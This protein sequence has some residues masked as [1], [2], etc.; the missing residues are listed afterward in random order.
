MEPCK[1]NYEMPDKKSYKIEKCTVVNIRKEIAKRN[2]GN[3]QIPYDNIILVDM[4]DDQVYSASTALY[5]T[6]NNREKEVFYKVYDAATLYKEKKELQIKYEKNQEELIQAQQEKNQLTEE[7][8][9]KEIEYTDR[10][11]QL[12]QNNNTKIADILKNAQEEINKCNKEKEDQI[13]KVW[14][15]CNQIESELEQKMHQNNEQAREIT[16]LKDDNGK[17]FNQVQQLCKDLEKVKLEKADMLNKWQNYHQGELNKWNNYIQNYNKQNCDLQQMNEQLKYEAQALIDNISQKEIDMAKLTKQL[18]IDKE[19]Y[20][21]EKKTMEEQ[22]EQKYNQLEQEKAQKDKVIKELKKVN[23]EQE[24]TI[25]QTNI[26]KDDKVQTLQDKDIENRKLIREVKSLNL[27]KQSLEDNNKQLIYQTQQLKQQIDNYYLK[28]S[29]LNAKIEED[30]EEIEKKNGELTQKNQQIDKQKRECQSLQQQKSTVEKDNQE[31]KSE[32][33][34]LKSD[35]EEQN[36]G[37]QNQ[38]TEIQKLNGQIKRSELELQNAQQQNSALQEKYRQLQKI[39]S[40]KDGKISS[41]EIQL[42]QCQNTLRQRELELQD[43]KKSFDSFSVRSQ[44]TL[45]HLQQELESQMQQQSVK[46]LIIKKLSKKSQDEKQHDKITG[47]M[48]KLMLS[49]FKINKFLEDANSLPDVQQCQIFEITIDY[50]KAKQYLQKNQYFQFEECL[51]KTNKGNVTIKRNLNSNAESTFFKGYLSII[52]EAAANEYKNKHLL[53]KE[54]ISQTQPFLNLDEAIEISKNNFLCQ[55]LMEHFNRSLKSQNMQ[56]QGTSIA[57]QFVLKPQDKEEYYYCEMVEEGDCR[58]INGGH[59]IPQLN[60]S[61]FNAFSKYVCYLSN[62]NYTITHIH[63]CGNYIY[64]MIVSTNI[65]GLF[66]PLDQ[67]PTEIGQFL[68]IINSSPANVINRHWNNNIEDT[69]KK[70]FI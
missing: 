41:L 67:G 19:K 4:K 8:K 32:I 22:N 45:K 23:E 27:E 49:A 47:L 69:A 51:I 43:Q 66:S 28:I 30:N 55:I 52:N 3:N 13:N 2:N 35:L 29:E 34:K 50:E 26:V 40:D 16:N 36:F 37:G 21:R 38:Q 31:L 1:V 58:K 42:G 14:K 11:N 12:S 53:R 25:R 57:R 17:L 6:R 68:D 39:S 61:Y 46:D 70:G 56:A 54:L 7:K 60:D 63:A 62:Q 48:E 9:N 10:I 5:Q 64:D 65:K 20:E 44:E 15:K 18:K 33:Q 59:F 24:D